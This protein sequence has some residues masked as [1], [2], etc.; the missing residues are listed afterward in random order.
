VGVRLV[1]YGSG[2]IGVAGA[3]AAVGN[4]ALKAERPSCVRPPFAGP[5]GVPR[6]GGLGA[7]PNPV[8]L[9]LNVII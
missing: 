8:R 3:A 2:R 1:K 5:P 4:A 6:W 7:Y 9:T